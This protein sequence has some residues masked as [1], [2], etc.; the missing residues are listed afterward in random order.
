M[1]LTAVFCGVLHLHFNQEMEMPLA[2]LATKLERD[3]AFADSKCPV[4]VCPRFIEH[5]PSPTSLEPGTVSYIGHVSVV[6][7]D[8]D[9]EFLRRCI[10]IINR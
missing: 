9:E 3:E 10:C 2:L 1:L 7:R 6:Q 8:G 5:R 4:E